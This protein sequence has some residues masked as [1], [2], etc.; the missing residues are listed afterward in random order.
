MSSMAKWFSGNNVL[1]PCQSCTLNTDVCMFFV[2]RIEFTFSLRW[3]CFVSAVVY[4][5]RL[6][7]IWTP[8]NI[9]FKNTAK[10]TAN[11]IILLFE[12][13]VIPSIALQ[14]VVTHEI[15][16]QRIWMYC[17]CCILN[18]YILHSFSGCVWRVFCV[19]CD[20]QIYFLGTTTES[21]TA[22]AERTVN[23]NGNRSNNNNN[24][25][26]NYTVHRGHSILPLT[27]CWV[28]AI[29]ATIAAATT[30]TS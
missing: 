28:D 10:T 29:A 11:K 2:H 26:E 5:T 30:E 4:E 7:N 23:E 13:V 6:L 9:Q 25:N 19:W 22:P 20:I 18:I 1:C 12:C 14:L 3:P 21:Q 17:R 15:S 24:E 16:L 27:R 8:E